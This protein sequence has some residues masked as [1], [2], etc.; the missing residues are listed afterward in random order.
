MPTKWL[1]MMIII[2]MKKVVLLEIKT[3]YLF[4]AA[5]GFD[6]DLEQKLEWEILDKNKKFQHLTTNIEWPSGLQ[7]ESMVPKI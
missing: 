3:I 1:I 6:E 4:I 2:I 7:F 5:K